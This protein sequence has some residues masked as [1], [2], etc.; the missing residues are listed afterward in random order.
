[1]YH[2]ISDYRFRC[3]QREI[4]ALDK[5]LKFHS[6]EPHYIVGYLE[7][8]LAFIKQDLETAEAVEE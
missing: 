4:E 2:K 8:S 5:T 6:H 3:L 1:M 7:A